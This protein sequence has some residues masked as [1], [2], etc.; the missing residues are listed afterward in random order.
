MAAVLP[1]YIAIDDISRLKS[2]IAINDAINRNWTLTE[3]YT[4]NIGH[5]LCC[6]S[7]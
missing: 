6:V 4:E 5:G 2:Y 1:R 7:C 3:K